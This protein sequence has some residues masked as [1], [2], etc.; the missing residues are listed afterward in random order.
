VLTDERRAAATAHAAEV[1]HAMRAAC[2]RLPDPDPM[3]LF[4]H[5]YTTAHSGIERQK[6]RYARYLDSFED[7]R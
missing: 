5:V 1:A 4:E 6:D 2:T 3:S 7:A